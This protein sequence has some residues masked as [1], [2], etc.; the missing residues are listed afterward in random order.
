MEQSLIRLL[1]ANEIECRIAAI[2][3]NGLSLLLYKD[4][5]VDQRILDETFGAF[6][7]KRSHQCIDGNLYCTVEIYDK[8]SG[9]WVSKQDVGTTGYTEK[10]KS[11][12]S[13]S[14]KRACFNWGIGRE[15]YSAPFIWIPAGK[16]AIQAKAGQNGEMRYYCND[17]FSVYSIQY[18]GD[19]EINA[20]VIVNDKGQPVYELKA[21]AAAEN[22]NKGKQ[23][24]K[25]AEKGQK[26]NGISKEQMTSLQAELDRT[27]VA[28]EVVQSR[29]KIQ[30]PETMNEDTYNKVMLALS[31]TKSVKAA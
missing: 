20:L 9:A 17:R 14:F 13:D 18:N 1:K 2:K 4:A 29:Y 7:W 5:R 16:A 21:K 26:K 25:T 22:G 28:M 30:T 19:R 11:Q 10:E 31:R 8:E 27:G 3:E 15:L 6:G 23:A 24:S 12:A